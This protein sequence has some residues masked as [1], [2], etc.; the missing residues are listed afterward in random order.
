MTATTGK[1]AV[2]HGEI[3]GFVGWLKLHGFTP[4]VTE[5]SRAD[6][7]NLGR[8]DRFYGGLMA[9]DKIL[10]VQAPGVDR[11]VPTRF[12]NIVI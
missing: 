1:T 10:L 12:F 3:N 2:R 7:E 4:Q 8:D 6:L 9:G 11:E 5:G